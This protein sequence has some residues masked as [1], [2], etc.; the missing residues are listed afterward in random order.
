MRSGERHSPIMVRTFDAKNPASTRRG[1]TGPG[2]IAASQPS[3]NCC[4]SVSGSNGWCSISVPPLMSH[5]STLTVTS[6]SEA[7]D[8]EP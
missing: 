4:A 7:I 5:G 1:T 6:P 3:R 8:S 2:R